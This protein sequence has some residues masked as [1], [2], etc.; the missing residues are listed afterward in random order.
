MFQGAPVMNHQP[1]CCDACIAQHDKRETEAKSL[2]TNDDDERCFPEFTRS[3]QR[4]RKSRQTFNHDLSSERNV[5]FTEKGS[6]LYSQVSLMVPFHGES[7]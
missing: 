2:Y 6:P 3:S 4:G 1:C 5:V 7:F